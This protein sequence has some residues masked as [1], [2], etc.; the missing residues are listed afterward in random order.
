MNVCIL[1]CILSHLLHT[2]GED[3]TIYGV[4]NNVTKHN[5]I[6][7]FKAGSWTLSCIYLELQSKEWKA[8]IDNHISER[9]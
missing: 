4:N 8:V 2:S 9:F 7:N 1:L 6:I 3:K 5:V